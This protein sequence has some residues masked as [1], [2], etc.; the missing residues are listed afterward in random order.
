MWT[1]TRIGLSTGP[2]YKRVWCATSR[3]AADEWTRV[4]VA[5]EA[6]GTA[7]FERKWEEYLETIKGQLEDCQCAS[8]KQK[9]AEH[10]VIYVGR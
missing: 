5:Q 9:R 3:W 8:C 10:D 1:R 7:T 4:L 2:S 6:P